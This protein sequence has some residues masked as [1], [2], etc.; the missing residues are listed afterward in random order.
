MKQAELQ[1]VSPVEG[2][3]KVTFVGGAVRRFHAVWLRD[4]A[5]GARHPRTNQRLVEVAALPE[6]PVIEAAEVR[7]GDLSVRW[8]DGAEHTF[9]GRLL[10][11]HA[12]DGALRAAARTAWRRGVEL[13]RVEAAALDA[14]RGRADWLEAFFALGAARVTGLPIER[15]EVA[16]FA[17]RFG[18]VRETNYGRIFDVESTPDPNH[19]AYADVP[20]ALHTDNPYR[21]PVPGLQLLHCLE[22]A[23]E[24]GDTVLVDG[25]AL[26]ERLAE[27]DP[28]AYEVLCRVQVPFRFRD[29]TC[30]LRA[31]RPIFTLD[32]EGEVVRVAFNDRSMAPLDCDYEDVEPFYAAFR[33]LDALTKD[34]E[35]QAQFRLE[36][37]EL[38]LFDNERI[39]HARTGFDSS[40]GRRHLQGCYAD[41]DA[42]ESA[43]RMLHFTS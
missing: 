7:E 9:S 1:G 30:D 29:D 20:L 2:G 12:Y 4:N 42:F 22:A 27:E 3:L 6:A 24:G 33:R 14:D 17:E 37:G 40:Q 23:K 16:R 43:L 21:E 18:F 26:A 38:L 19:L 15:G 13:P 5:P 34:P 10:W 25:L 32:S 28:Q 39:L 8:A 41:R 36:P 31:R 35:M 11:D